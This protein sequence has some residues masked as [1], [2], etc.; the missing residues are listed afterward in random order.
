[1]NSSYLSYFIMPAAGRL[2]FLY[3]TALWNETQLGSSTV[4][5]Y[6]GHEMTDDGIIFSKINYTILFQRARQTSEHEIIIPY[7]RFRMD[8][9][10][11]VRF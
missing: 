8:G 10:A 1:L 9:F 3:N 5:D 6:Q 4:L 2:F 7:Q 11:V